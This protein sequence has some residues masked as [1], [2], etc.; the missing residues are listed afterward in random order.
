MFN[1]NSRLLVL[2]I[3]V[4]ASS[5]ISA[6]QPRDER[7]DD[8]TS[9]TISGRVVSET[10]Q[11]I[12]NAV[13]YVRALNST[14][15]RT[16]T[17][18]ADGTFVVRGLDPS[19]FG[20][21]ASLPTYVNKPREP[22]SQPIFYRS[23][24]NVT[25]ELNRGGVITGTVTAPNGDPVVAMRVRAYLIRF[26]DGT[27][28]RVAGTYGERITDDRG[29]YR[30]YGLPAGVY[31]VAAGGAT[32]VYYSMSAYDSEGQTFAPSSTRDTATEFTVRSG[33][34]TTNADI[35][36][37]GEGGQRQRA[38]AWSNVTVFSDADSSL[39]RNAW[40]HHLPTARSYKF[41][42]FGNFGRNV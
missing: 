11:P 40:D 12:S 5:G 22:D 42:F 32:S 18:S 33:E 39:N 15:S 34:E 23:G 20:I 26:G 16:T 21:F 25:I 1:Q 28:P 36:Y 17:T 24:D 35:R 37:R 13:I 14:Q 29:I 3:G 41:R 8:R 30:L 2:L 19:L 6:Q 7:A 9:G 4:L 38:R 10:G 31:L 27:R